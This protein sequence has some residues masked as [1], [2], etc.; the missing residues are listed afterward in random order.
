MSYRLPFPVFSIMSSISAF[1]PRIII[2]I[3]YRFALHSPCPTTTAKRRPPTP[4]YP[5]LFASLFVSFPSLPSLLL[6]SSS[7]PPFPVSRVRLLN[8]RRR[9]RRRRSINTCT[10]LS[11]R[12]HKTPITKWRPLYPP[13]RYRKATRFSP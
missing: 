1:C 8:H 11:Y 10:S 7:S 3:C 12:P 2:I 13:A 4:P 6:R 5:R 9:R